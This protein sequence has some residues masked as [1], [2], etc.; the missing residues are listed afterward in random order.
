MTNSE[1]EL[2]MQ[3]IFRKDKKTK[4]IVAFLPEIPVSRYMIMSYM[5]IGQHSEASLDYYFLSTEKASEE[6]YCNLYEELCN[7]YYDEKIVIRR[8]LNKDLLVKSWMA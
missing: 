3:V 2:S 6:E 7:V 8:R 1:G 4:E 5:H